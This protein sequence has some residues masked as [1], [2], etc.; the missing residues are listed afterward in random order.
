[1]WLGYGSACWIS[2]DL[3]QGAYCGLALEFCAR[4]LRIEDERVLYIALYCI[5][6][7]T[8]TSSGLYSNVSNRSHLLNSIA[9]DPGNPH[10]HHQ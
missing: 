1:M 4:G 10:E 8:S 3:L 5:K 7:L 6:K 9:Q 2:A